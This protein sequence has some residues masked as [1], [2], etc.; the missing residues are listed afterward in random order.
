MGGGRIIPSLPP[1]HTIEI[2]INRFS[3][4]KSRKGANK[5]ETAFMRRY[6]VHI[7]KIRPIADYNHYLFSFTNSMWGKIWFIIM[8]MSTFFFSIKPGKRK[9]R[10]GEMQRFVTDVWGLLHQDVFYRTNE[11]EQAYTG[12]NFKNVQTKD[13]F[14]LAGI[15]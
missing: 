4:K 1:N 10:T 11:T 15:G 3:I 13:V 6:L 9:E 12:T 8:F 14:V 7:K 5:K 2:R